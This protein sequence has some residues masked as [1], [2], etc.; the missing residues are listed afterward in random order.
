MEKLKSAKKSTKLKS[1]KLAR[2]ILLAM[3]FGLLTGLILR[4]IPQVD[5]IQ[6]YLIDGLLYIIG[7]LFISVITMLVVPIVFISLVCGTCHLSDIRH[8]GALAVK[9]VVLYIFTTA[10]A[11]SLAIFFAHFLHIGANSYLNLPSQF[12]AVQG[13]SIKQVLLNLI[14]TNPFKAMVKGNMIQVIIFSILLGIAIAL[15]GEAGK[16][17]AA[18][19]NNFNVVVMKLI[20]MIM[21]T[22]PVGVFCLIANMVA[23][24]GFSVIYDLLGYF[25]TVLL[26][27]FF[28]L[29]VVYPSLLYSLARLNPVVFF[30]KMY[31]A[32]AFAF[33]IS[34]SNASI[35]V[36]LDSVKRKLGVK[37]TVA[38]FVIPLGSTINMDGTSIMQGVA[39]VFIANLYHIDIGLTGY[40]TVVLMATLAS[41]GTAG[42]PSVGLITLTMVLNQ[43][44][45]PTEAIALIIGV[46]RLL[47]MTRTAVNIAGDATIACIV[48]KSEKQLDSKTYYS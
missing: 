5:F 9:T 24:L 12:V 27:L 22:A 17:V 10:I 43:V 29:L 35:P 7:K 37:N 18:V 40:L 16:K 21:Y 44:G 34:S 41:I 33:S 23:K 14:P 3:L 46:D 42:V 26:V 28:Q 19:F 45:L 2:N 47:D 6:V 13:P 38:A 8:F 4:L 36:V 39:T 30:K 11:I 31:S 1:T 15:S 32:M 48:G 25:F 20:T